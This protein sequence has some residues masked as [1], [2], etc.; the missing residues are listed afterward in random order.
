MSRAR[1]QIKVDGTQVP[2]RAISSEPIIF[3]T[4]DGK[5]QG[6][7]C[8]LW[9]TISRLP[10]GHHRLTLSGESGSFRTRVTYRLRGH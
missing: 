7:G 10:A 6:V 2:L 9:A 1:G 5:V 3:D 4:S 8:G